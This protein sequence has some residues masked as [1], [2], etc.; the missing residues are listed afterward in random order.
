MDLQLDHL[1]DC[2]FCDACRGDLGMGQ[3]EWCCW[4]FP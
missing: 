3:E 1:I 4:A 2:D